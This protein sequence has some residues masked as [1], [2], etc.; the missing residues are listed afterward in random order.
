MDYQVGQKVRVQ[1]SP[2]YK[3]ID[4][5]RKY[6]GMDMKI[7]KRRMVRRPTKYGMLT[8]VTRIYYELEG[9]ESQKHVPYGFLQEN[10]IPIA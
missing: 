6:H 5:S 8:D 10:L 9:A 3:I 1:F 4:G 2:S 7:S